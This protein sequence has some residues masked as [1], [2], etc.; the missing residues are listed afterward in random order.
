MFKK[1]IKYTDYFGEERERDFFFNLTKAELM[2]MNL[3]KDG[4]LERLVERITQTND[5]K[6]LVDIF[7]EIIFK[8][9]GEKSADGDRF[10]KSD[11]LS[12]AFSQTP[13]YDILFMELAT[14]ADAAADFINNVVPADLA[15]KMKDNQQKGMNPALAAIQGREIPQAIPK[16][17]NGN[18]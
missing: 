18:N 2:E 9:Y 11:E 4:G 3:S 1:R 13:A 5:Q 12:I 8:S 7:K 16:E 10:I 15:Q 6:Q 17:T 14:D